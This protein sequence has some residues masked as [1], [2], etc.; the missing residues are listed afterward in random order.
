[1]QRVAVTSSDIRSV[2]YDPESHIIEVE[3]K[4]GWIYQYFEVPPSVHGAL[5]KSPSHGRYFAS[6]IK[7]VY[8]YRRIR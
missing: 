4:S 8:R 7:N 1:M 6:H 2:G 3:F 5:M